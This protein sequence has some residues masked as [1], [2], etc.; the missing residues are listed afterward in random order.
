MS[1]FSLSFQIPVSSSTPNSSISNMACLPEETGMVP[2]GISVRPVTSG[3]PLHLPPM[4]N[5]DSPSPPPPP[6]Y[7]KLRQN[8]SPQNANID[9]PM[10]SPHQT[11]V[12]SEDSSVALCL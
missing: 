5:G 1:S 8:P 3:D 4:A 9:R 2:N 10:V 7:V 6:I 11:D 12:K